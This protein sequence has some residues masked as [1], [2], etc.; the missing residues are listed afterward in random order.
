MV[1]VASSTPS[2]N[3]T[4]AG[5]GSIRS[6]TPVQ[7]RPTVIG[8]DRSPERRSGTVAVAPRSEAWPST[9]PTRTRLQAVGSTPWC[10]GIHASS[11]SAR[12][13]AKAARESAESRTP[14]QT[15]SICRPSMG[16]PR[17]EPWRAVL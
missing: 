9:G 14:S 6:T 10:S 5:G 11:P 13:S 4:L 2:G 7:V 8:S 1:A 12:A 15:A 16:P 3:D 17:W